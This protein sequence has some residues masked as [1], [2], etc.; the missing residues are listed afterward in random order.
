MYFALSMCHP[1]CIT[2]WQRKTNKKLLT[3]DNATC[4]NAMFVP[5]LCEKTIQVITHLINIVDVL[6]RIWCNIRPIK[7]HCSWYAIHRRISSN[8][9]NNNYRLKDN[10]C[11][12]D[13]H[14]AFNRNP[15]ISADP[16]IHGLGIQTR[17]VRIV[18]GSTC[19]PRS[20]EYFGSVDALWVFHRQKVQGRQWMCITSYFIGSLL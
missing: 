5:F 17:D 1:M 4:G 15:S 3:Y 11:E 19:E 2:Q 13:I 20:T 7:P 9:K 18:G 12:G 10:K 8:I 16:Q 14:C 6:H